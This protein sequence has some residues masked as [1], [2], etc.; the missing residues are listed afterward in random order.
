MRYTTKRPAAWY[1]FV[2]SGDGER[3]PHPMVTAREPEWTGLVDAD[4][5]RIY[6]L[7][8]PIGFLPTKEV[9]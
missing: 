7:P 2:P 6:R 3:L 8:D 1:E 9:S 5:R 4:G